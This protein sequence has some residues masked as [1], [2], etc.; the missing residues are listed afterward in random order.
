MPYRLADTLYRVRK[1]NRKR[2]PVPAPPPT[3]EQLALFAEHEEWVSYHVFLF[4]RWRARKAGLEVADLLQAGRMGLWDAILTFDP[5][6]GCKMAT[7]CRKRIYWSLYEAVERARYG[8]V[9]RNRPLVDHSLFAALEDHD[10]PRHDPDP[11]DS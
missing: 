3:A 10:Q 6:S 7:H 8:R 1:P 9:R 11:E 4:G 5:S 2:R